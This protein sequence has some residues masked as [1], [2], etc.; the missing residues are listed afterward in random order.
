MLNG[1]KSSFVADL[2]TEEGR[3]SLRPLI[4]KADVIVE[5]FRPG[6]MERL[7][8]GYEAAR[9][10]NPRIVYCSISGYG[11]SRAGGGA[12][13]QLPGPHRAVVVVARNR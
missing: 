7:G 1:G 10:I 2:K 12:R 3:A 13:H 11:P 8:L 9:A 5:Q 4:E 6:V